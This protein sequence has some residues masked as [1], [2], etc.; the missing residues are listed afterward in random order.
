VFMWAIFYNLFGMFIIY[1]LE[2]INCV[3]IIVMFIVRVV[4][5]KNMIVDMVWSVGFELRGTKFELGLE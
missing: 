5:K 1:F 4:K 2:C 3:D